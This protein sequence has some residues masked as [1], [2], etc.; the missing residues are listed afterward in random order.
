LKKFHDLANS[1]HPRIKIELKFSKNQIEFLDTITVLDNGF[2]GLKFVP[3]NQKIDMTE[4]IANVKEWERRMRLREF[5]FDQN[6]KED[7][8]TDDQKQYNFIKKKKSNWT[9]PTGRSEWLDLY[10][11]LVKNDII[12]GVKQKYRINLNRAEEEALQDLLSDQSI[13]IRPCDN[14]NVFDHQS[15]HLLSHSDQKRIP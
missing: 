6:E 15:K 10:L 12:S 1:I 8:L 3:T 11:K 14:C 2:L 5:F 4:L 9:P 7:V 13:V